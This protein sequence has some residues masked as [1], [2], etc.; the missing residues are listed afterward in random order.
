VDGIGQRHEPGLVDALVR[1]DFGN[2][3]TGAPMAPTDATD[4]QL[5]ILNEVYVNDRRAGESTT[6]DLQYAA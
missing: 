4:P 5:Q 2:T 6:S 1:H 3:D